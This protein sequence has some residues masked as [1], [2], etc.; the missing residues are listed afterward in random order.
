MYQSSPQAPERQRPRPRYLGWLTVLLVL[1]GLGFA[2][3]RVAARIVQGAFEQTITLAA[4]QAGT[5]SGTTLDIHNEF[6]FLSQLLSGRL[7]EVSGSIEHAYL[8]NFETLDFQFVATG[9]DIPLPTMADLGRRIAGR[10]NQIPLQVEH[11]QAEGL[12]PYY[13][14]NNLVDSRV[15]NFVGEIAVSPANDSPTQIAISAPGI[16]IEFIATPTLIPPHTILVEIDQV[17]LAGI[18]I[19]PNDLPFGLGDQIPNQFQF[20]LQLPAG[21]SLTNFTIE[22]NGLRISISANDVDLMQYFA[23]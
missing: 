12:I 1:A 18:T 10:P 16:G 13:V 23:R 3:D 2:A 14:F 11:I 5:I 7:S 20:D 15:G 8:G 6:P 9:V 19:N 4:E 22:L 21:A 17:I